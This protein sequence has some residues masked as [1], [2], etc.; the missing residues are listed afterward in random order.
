MSETLLGVLIGGAIGSVAPLIALFWDQRRWRQEKRLM[1]LQSE[2]QR[3]E[4]LFAA[5]YEK[6][7]TAMANN[8]YPIDM[9]ADLG[10]LM[11][12]E[13]NK[14]FHEWMEKSPKDEADARVALLEISLSMR[15]ALA[16]LDKKIEATIDK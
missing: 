15:E 7:G 2:R 3:M 14:R 8:S 10:V 5:T 16:A 13:V 6:L 12:K 4:H 11:P 1:Y 9:L